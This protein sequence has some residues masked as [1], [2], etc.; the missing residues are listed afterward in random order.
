[1]LRNI[2]SDTQAR[3]DMVVRNNATWDDAF[4][5]GDPTDT[6]WTLTGQSFMAEVKG[7]R[8][9]ATALAILTTGD[10]SIVVDD[11]DL[12]VIHFHYSDLLLVANL[13][14]GE[15][16][17]DLVMIDDSTGDRVNLMGGKVEVK[18]GVTR[19]PV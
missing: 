10:G 18:Q 16:V 6:T 7:S 8:E 15:Y 9:D 12:R 13:V 1:M 17:Y 2:A 5:F 19:D 11:V 4:Q 14:P 3:V